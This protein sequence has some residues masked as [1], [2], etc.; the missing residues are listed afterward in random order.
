[1]LEVKRDEV[2]ASTEVILRVKTPEGSKEHVNLKAWSLE[3]IC[4]PIETVPWPDIKTNWRHLD[5]LDCRP[6]GGEVDILL[7]LDHADLLVQ[8]EIKT[9]R[10]KESCCKDAQKMKY[11]RWTYYNMEL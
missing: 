10:P 1:M 7:G 4:Q 8:L 3:S 11:V 2:K 9:G 6:I 5:K